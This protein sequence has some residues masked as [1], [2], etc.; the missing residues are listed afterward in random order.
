MNPKATVSTDYRWRLGLVG[1][2]VMFFSL[3]F[4]YDGLI[5]YPAKREI[6]QQ[7]EQFV[8]VADYDG[9]RAYAIEQGLWSEADPGYPDAP[10]AKDNKSDWD[11][12]VQVILGALCFPIGG[13]FLWTWFASGRWWVAS[14]GQT[15]STH[16]GESV[17]FEAIK[18]IDTSRWKSKG[19]AVV[20]YEV[21]GKA[22]RIVLDDWKYRRAPVVEI[23]RQLDGHLNPENAEAS[24]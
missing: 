6:Y 24:S 9:W 18:S 2:M 11:I 23:Y 3:W 13:M 14:D 12:A 4:F 17:P 19:I 10:D 5:G 1:A 20:H 8:Q 22:G 15:L 21:E 16:R 7:Y